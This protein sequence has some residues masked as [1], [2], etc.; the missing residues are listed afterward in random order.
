MLI[1]QAAYAN[2]WRT[3]TPGAKALFAG[4]GLVAAFL[5]AAT[6]W[7]AA[8]VTTCLALVTLVGAGIA[9]RLYLRV[10]APALGFLAIGCLSLTYSLNFDSDSGGLSLAASAS[11][12]TQALETGARALTA[13]AALLFLVLS[14]PLSD[15]IALLRRLQMPE[16]L[17]DIMVLC[18]RTLFVFSAALRDIHTAQAARLGYAAPRLALRSSALLL[19]GLVGQIWQRA[20]ALHLAAEARNGDGPLRFLAPPFRHARRDTTIAALA[21][22]ALIALAASARIAARWHPA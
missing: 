18:Y 1:E 5:A 20:H 13:L 22:L 9:P 7:Q 4:C 10:A 14:T 8:A 19:A 3:V 6:P 15:L 11:G 12:R 16:I 17:L 21:G 2:R